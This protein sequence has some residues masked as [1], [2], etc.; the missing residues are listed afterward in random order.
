M[1]NLA[2]SEAILSLL[3]GAGYAI[4]QEG[5][6]TSFGDAHWDL[7]NGRQ[8]LRLT[9]DRGQYLLSANYGGL[10]WVD[11]GDLMGEHAPPD[12]QDELL[13]A[14]FDGDFPQRLG[15]LL[16]AISHIVESPAL[17]EEINQRLRN[18][19]TS[20]LGQSRV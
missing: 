6:S 9:R 17:D 5:H 18:R 19:V 15:T 16:L 10:G 2:K 8:S 1:Q 14:R 7:S 20:V 3:V 11:I 12:V 13:N 4:T